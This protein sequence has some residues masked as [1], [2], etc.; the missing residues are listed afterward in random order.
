MLLC[1]YFIF[2]FLRRKSRSVIPV[3]FWFK[4][5]LRS[6]GFPFLLKQLFYLN[7][8]SIAMLNKFK[9]HWRSKIHHWPFTFLVISEGFEPSTFGL[10]NR[11]SNLLSYEIVFLNKI[12]FK[13][14][15]RE[16]V[17]SEIFHESLRSIQESNLQSP[18]DSRE[19]CH[20]LNRPFLCDSL[21][22]V[23]F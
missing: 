7:D 5:R 23:N 9:I 16:T 18:R 2:C 19:G 20:Y 4:D 8:E 14:P 15:F 12:H 10:W 13:N 1:L 22:L 6:T 17:G 11:Y 3:F 21:S